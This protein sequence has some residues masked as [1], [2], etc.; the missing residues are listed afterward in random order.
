VQPIQRAQLSNAL[1]LHVY[2]TRSRNVCLRA[3]RACSPGCDA[4]DAVCAITATLHCNTRIEQYCMT[5]RLQRPCNK[6]QHSHV[7]VVKHML[8]CAPQLHTPCCCL[9]FATQLAGKPTFGT[10]H[11]DILL[12]ATVPNAAGFL[13][14]HS[15]YGTCQ[16]ALCL[17]CLLNTTLTH[18]HA[19]SCR[20][21][22]QHNSN[23][24]A[25]NS[26]S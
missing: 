23:C 6:L 1:V 22:H 11:R 17:R 21:I 18:V 5:L 10:Q 14:P 16:H 25:C 3:I 24:Y 19:F 4:D 8:A 9:P 7:C 26:C 15:F 12:H 20:N 13:V 2:M